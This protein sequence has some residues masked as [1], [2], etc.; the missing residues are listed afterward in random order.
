MSNNDEQGKKSF[1]A[2]LDA[3]EEIEMGDIAKMYITIFFGID[4]DLDFITIQ[5]YIA[6]YYCL[7]RLYLSVELL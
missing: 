7:K 5:V 4:H 2:S 3:G 6:Y 1:S